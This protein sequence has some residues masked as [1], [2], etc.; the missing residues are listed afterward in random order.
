MEMWLLL[1]PFAEISPDY[2]I[3]MMLLNRCN[4]T[5]KNVVLGLFSLT[6]FWISLH[7][8]I[9]PFKDAPFIPS[10]VHNE[11][12]YLW[13]VPNRLVYSVLQTNLSKCPTLCTPH[14]HFCIQSQWKCHWRRLLINICVYWPRGLS[15]NVTESDDGL[16]T[17]V[18][19]TKL[20]TKLN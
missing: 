11:P 4:C 16:H 20:T 18:T 10:H 13:N 17:L 6:V 8:V 7:P 12:A 3:L 2:L 14:C 1:V 19:Y 5:L 9:D 15:L